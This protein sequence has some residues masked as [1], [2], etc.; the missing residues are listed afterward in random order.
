MADASL[1]IAIASAAIALVAL[2]FAIVQA[3]TAFSQ[4]VASV[5]R[6]SRSVTG[7]F[8]LR[9][10]IWLNIITLSINPRYR[11]PV[12]TMPGLRQ[13]TP[14]MEQRQSFPD[15]VVYG[16]NFSR[17]LN[18]YKDEGK[19]RILGKSA[20]GA[21]G[22]DNDSGKIKGRIAKRETLVALIILLCIT[23]FL[24]AF[25]LA[26]I[27]F[28]IPCDLRWAYK[29]SR[30]REYYLDDYDGECGGL[31]SRQC[32]L[33]PFS[34]IG[35]FKD[36]VKRRTDDDAEAVQLV[37]KSET[38]A[39]EAASWVQLLMNYQIAW[40]GYASIRWEWRLASTIPAD[41]LGASAETT[42]ADLQ[43]LAMIGGM[44][45]TK[46]EHVLARSH[47]G[48]ELVFSM[49]QILGRIVFYRSGRE[50]IR[51]EVW[52]AVPSRNLDFLYHCIE[53]AR[54]GNTTLGKN[55]Y[56]QRQIDLEANDP[57]Q[58]EPLSKIDI[59]SAL[60]QLARQ[61]TEYDAQL[62]FSCGNAK[63]IFRTRGFIE[64]LTDLS[65][66]IGWTERKCLVLWGPFGQGINL[67]SCI[68]C[69]DEWYKSQALVGE[70]RNP[71]CS[72]PALLDIAFRYQESGEDE[73]EERLP[74]VG[75]SFYLT[76][77]QIQRLQRKHS[78]PEVSILLRKVCHGG[79]E[80]GRCNCGHISRLKGA[81][82]AEED[83]P[84]DEILAVVAHNT[85]WLGKASRQ[86]LTQAAEELLLEPLDGKAKSPALKTLRSVLSYT[87]TLLPS[88]RQHIGLT[89]I[90]NAVQTPPLM[91]FSPIVLGA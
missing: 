84:L 9:Q 85:R 44:Y 33:I 10:G 6:C 26:M 29:Y 46:E 62:P 38:Q 91:D 45:F 3:I 63:W 8:D 82:L 13:R 49:H 47:C 40:W 66:S 78:V 65:T 70:S 75:P 30:N 52:Q 89:D 28:C 83:P 14:V 64:G 2:L 61:R 22:Q 23:P 15:D 77:G 69:C 19:I 1:V 17:V 57:I 5:N 88:I 79:C 32:A 56:K 4:Y 20:L 74:F 24:A 37:P 54:K 48:E 81:P 87:E 43:L 50:N 27:P 41:M 12:M 18:G 67:C 59:A 76:E 21:S 71:K 68:Q 53:V 31:S 86:T 39:L 7:A 11:M 72:L 25:G 36:V 60:N 80:D 16:E 42:V 58:L 35:M 55:R 51:S 34:F 73:D 90:W